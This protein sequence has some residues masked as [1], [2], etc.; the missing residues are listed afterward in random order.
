LKQFSCHFLL[1]E[2]LNFHQMSLI[3]SESLLDHPHNSFSEQ[4][5]VLSQLA[6]HIFIEAFYFMV[7]IVNL[8]PH[9][10]R[11]VVET[12]GGLVSG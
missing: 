9:Q 6:K 7:N 12:V 1:L 5:G 10:I 2:P 11:Q 8:F 3:L 4:L